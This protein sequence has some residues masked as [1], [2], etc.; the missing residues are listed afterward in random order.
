MKQARDSEAIDF[1]RKPAWTPTIFPVV[2]AQLTVQPLEAKASAIIP[3]GSWLPGLQN[4]VENTPQLW[5]QKRPH[6]L[7]DGEVPEGFNSTRSSCK[8]CVAKAR[9][10]TQIQ[11]P[12]PMLHQHCSAIS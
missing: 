3:N 8:G 6:V 9:T 2:T 11:Y 12:E 4:K 10:G 5:G 1:Y 7:H